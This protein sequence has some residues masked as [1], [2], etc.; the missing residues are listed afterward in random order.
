[1]NKENCFQL[2]TI[3]KL[4][5]FKGEVSLFLDVSDYSKYADLDH[6]FLEMNGSLVPYFIELIKPKNKG[7]MVVKLEGI[8][9][10]EAARLILKKNVYLPDTFLDDLDEKSFYDHEIVGF[11]V[12]DSQKGEVGVVKEVIDL[13][14]NPLLSVN[15]KDKEIL[16]PIFKDLVQKIDRNERTLYI[17]APEGLLDIYI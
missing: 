5:G 7:F 17:Q 10:E 16:I 8:D 14:S 11:T 3:A 12:I 2:G 13:K 9:N 4:H 15:F 6:F 1:M